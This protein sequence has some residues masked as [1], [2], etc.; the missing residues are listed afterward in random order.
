MDFTTLLRIYLTQVVSTIGIIVVFGYLIGLC[1]TGFYHNLRKFG[2]PV[3]YAT[4][5]IG[6]PIHEASHALFCILFGHRITYFNPFCLTD[7][8]NSMLW[9]QV[10]HTYNRNNIYQQI[11]NF[12]IGIGPLLVMSTG[13][14][15]LTYYLLP[16]FTNNAIS[17]L[18][19]IESFSFSEIWRVFSSMVVSFFSF[20][21]EPIWWLIFAIVLIL[22]LH[23]TLSNADIKGATSGAITLLL[24]WF[25]TDLALWKFD[26]RTL[27]SITDYTIMIGALLTCIFAFALLFSLI[28]VAISAII[29]AA[30]K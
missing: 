8:P 24:I 11:G 19:S 15:L 4:A 14:F 5:L 2:T 1:H 6:A 7:D 21:N 29:K 9:A 10:H 25:L 17:L 3:F 28:A 27:S 26:A 23:M 30:T 16:D 18:T 22:S 12:F 13:I 20:A